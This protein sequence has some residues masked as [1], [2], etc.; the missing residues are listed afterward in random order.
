MAGGK[1]N[2]AGAG[3]FTERHP[4][5]IIVFEVGRIQPLPDVLALGQIPVLVVGKFKVNAPAKALDMRKLLSLG[6]VVGEAILGRC[7]RWPRLV[8]LGCRRHRPG[9]KPGGPEIHSRS[10]T[11]KFGDWHCHSQTRS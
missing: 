9:C 4:I 7:T 10:G 6:V 5:Q 1:G 8:R 3:L 2:V 11:P